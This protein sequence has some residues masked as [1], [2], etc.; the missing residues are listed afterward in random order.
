M[1][2]EFLIGCLLWNRSPARSWSD[3]YSYTTHNQDKAFFI[4]SAQK[5]R[6]RDLGVEVPLR[7]TAVVKLRCLSI[8]I[9]AII[10]N[11]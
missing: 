7:N 5:G 10:Y 9:H 11:C 4:S 2:E 8:N 6:M 3:V 1:M